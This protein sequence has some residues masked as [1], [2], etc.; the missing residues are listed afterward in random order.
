[1]D[2][3]RL[4]TAPCVAPASQCSPSSLLAPA[5]DTSVSLKVPN[6]GVLL[7]TITALP[8]GAQQKEGDLT[9]YTWL[10]ASITTLFRAVLPFF[11]FNSYGPHSF[12]CKNLNGGQ[13]QVWKL[14]LC[15]LCAQ[16]QHLVLF[17]E[18]RL[19]YCME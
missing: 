18:L 19:A 12:L 17:N 4:L 5:G 14:I 10:L 9:V 6:W 7:K 2:T 3:G 1:M 11:S 16:W 13:V 8:V 15:L